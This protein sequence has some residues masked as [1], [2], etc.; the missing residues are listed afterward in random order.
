VT[1]PNATPDR[2]PNPDRDPNRD[3]RYRVA[4]D[5]YTGPMDLLL[6]LIKRDEVDIYDIP[7]SRITQ[8]YIDYVDMLKEINPEL[9]SEFLVLAAT[10]MEI[11]SRTLLPRPP[12]EEDDE[13]MIDPRSELIRQLLEY[14]KFKDAARS[15]DE[16][17]KE[18][19]LKHARSPALPPHNPNDISLDNIDIW[20]LFEA[21]NKIL[22]KIGKAGA[23][24]KVSVDDT[25]IRLHAADMIDSLQRAGGEQRFE[26]IFIGRDRAEMIGLFLALLELIRRWRVK[27]TQPLA[28][29]DIHI[30]LLDPTPLGEEAESL[31]ES[32]EAQL[33]DEAELIEERSMPIED[34][35]RPAQED[36]PD[37]D[38]SD[39]DIVENLRVVDV[40]V[41]NMP[42]ADTTENAVIETTSQE[43]PTDDNK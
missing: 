38:S 18:H 36:G 20:N 40:E 26:E 11:K 10:L 16:S 3:P 13:E 17:A 23:V 5:V 15:L 12:V 37:D 42:A 43:E 33:A 2:N 7:I 21:F 35:E 32:D 25:P 9:V 41:A 19:A 24:H 27:A 1:D 6:F 22:A 8:Q 30:K 4:L 31:T 28:A 39:G 29:G 14:K 34:V